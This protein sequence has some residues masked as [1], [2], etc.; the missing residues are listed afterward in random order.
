MPATA[1]AKIASMTTANALPD[2]RRFPALDDL[3]R[4]L[5]ATCRTAAAALAAPTRQDAD[6]YDASLRERLKAALDGDGRTLEALVAG[7]P[8]ADVARHLLRQL[9]LAWREAEAAGGVTAHL[10]AL[11]VVVVTGL[12]AASGEGTLAGVLDD[13]PALA[14]ILAE[15]GALAGN[16]S[17]ALANVLTAAGA[18]DLAA[19]PA[20]RAW[21]RLPD[22]P[23]AGVALPA[24]AVPPAPLAFAAGREAV[25][26]R[27]IPGT[28]LARGGAEL[29]A[30][31]TVGKW[32][33]PFTQAL[34]R[35]LGGDRVSVLA[36]PRAP[37]RL[38][39]A[40]QAGRAA[41]REVSAQLFASNAIRKLRASVGEPSAVISAHRTA[42]APG[43]G[44]LRLSLSSP[45]EPR[46]AEGF[47]CPLYASDRV[48]DVVAMLRGLLADCRVND[49]RVVPG[50]H[51]DR[52]AG[53]GLPLLFKPETLPAGGDALH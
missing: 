11:P 29:T 39:A 26:L 35:Q 13:A 2:P 42:D 24:R 4:D 1:R 38:L 37:A 27:F 23:V 30:D 7:A 5:A 41:Q 31:A 48:A 51:A 18:I 49:V 6:R 36:L 40:V 21:Q 19:L 44:E 32:G 43:G 10:F 45:F 16:R 50:I 52:V 14:A 25:H 12:E 17:F 22:A 15:H 53:T 20:L 28:A 3:P 47:R 8:S 34:S 33:L 46:D 9:D